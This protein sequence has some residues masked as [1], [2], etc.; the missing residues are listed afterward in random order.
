VR[1]NVKAQLEK[2]NRKVEEAKSDIPKFLRKILGFEPFSYQLKFIDKFEQ[3]QFV[4][5]RWCWQSEARQTF[6]ISTFIPENNP[7]PMG[8]DPKKEQAHRPE[9][10]T[11]TL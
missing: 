5:A 8:L 11:I 9:R 7:E 6:L 10:R 2:E 1:Q 4:A 3:S